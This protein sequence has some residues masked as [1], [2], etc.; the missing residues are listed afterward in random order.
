MSAIT[1]GS[2]V[3]LIE[4]AELIAAIGATNPIL[5]RGE[6]GIGKSA[7]MKIL[8]KYLGDGYEYAYFDMGNK[9]DGDT[10]IPFPDK[11]RKVMEFFIN[12]ALKLHT[13]KPVVIMLDEFGKAPRA[14]QNMM[15]TLL[16]TTGKRIQDTYLPKGSIVFLTTN[17]AEEGLGDTL[18]DH[19]LDRLTVVEVR[20][21]NAD[22][23]KL[24]AVAN[25]IHPAL[26]AW[27]DQTPTCLASFREAGFDQNNSY[28]TNPKRVQA[29]VV[30]P[31]S[32]ELAS[33]IIWKRDKVSLNALTAALIGT[34]GGAAAHDIESYIAFQDDIPPREVI[35]KSPLTAPI[36]TSVGAIITLLFNLERAVEA[37]TITPIMQYV[38]RLD[39]EPQS[40]FCITLGRSET[41][42][43]IAFSNAEFTAW[44]QENQ[45]I[46]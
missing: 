27:V 40:M 22:E 42:Q 31:R 39:I 36:P 41:K 38:K 28:V 13:G 4:A 12:T 9:S 7:I 17:F 26:I 33:N 11:E 35:L 44:A 43:H 6:K 45:D 2:S 25:N 24:W 3:S 20:K 19:T 15:H 29:K 37:S 30:T 32:L 16:E 5:L 10:A 8:P 1:L 34:V 14:I 21:P 23:W 18:L 46:L